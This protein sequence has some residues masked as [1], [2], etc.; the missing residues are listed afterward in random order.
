MQITQAPRKY[1]DPEEMLVLQGKKTGAAI[2][3]PWSN[4]GRAG[5]TIQDY[6]KAWVDVCYDGGKAGKPECARDRVSSAVFWGMTGCGRTKIH[7][8]AKEEGPGRWSIV[9]FTEFKARVCTVSNH[10]SLGARQRFA[11]FHSWMRTCGCV[12]RCVSRSAPAFLDASRNPSCRSLMRPP[13]RALRCSMRPSVRALRPSIR[14][15]VRNS[16][17]SS[18]RQAIRRSI[19]HPSRHSIRHAIRPGWTGAGRDRGARR[20]TQGRI[21]RRIEGALPNTQVSMVGH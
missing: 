14:D 8:F 18:T 6:G 11:L 2:Y 13:I 4:G 19:R 16:I 21:E 17:C 7:H 5:S 15:A 1:Y 12:P 9:D 3:R 10:G 20:G